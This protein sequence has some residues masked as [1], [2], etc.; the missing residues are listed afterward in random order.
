[1]RMNQF[2]RQTALPGSLDSAGYS[3]RTERERY[4]DAKGWEFDHQAFGQAP[5]PLIKLNL[6]N[7][8]R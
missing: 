5:F 6:K 7:H 4:C 2:D 3:S 1:M 8:R